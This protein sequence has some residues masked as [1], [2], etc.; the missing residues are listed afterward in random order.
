MIGQ[1][2]IINTAS[3]ML[4]TFLPAISRGSGMSVEALGRVIFARDMTGLLGPAVGGVVRRAGAWRTMVWAGVLGAVGMLLVPF[5]VVGIVIGLV[6]WGLCRTSFIIALNSW[7]GDAVAYERRAR[8]TGLVEL[9]W[10]AAALIGLPLM[11]VLIDAVGWWMAPTILGLLG[12]PFAALMARIES[13]AKVAATTTQ[14]RSIVMSRNTIFALVAVAL[15]TGAAQFLLFTHGL[16]LES[17][18][19]FDPAQVGFAIVAVGAAEAVASYGTSLITDRLGKR[20]GVIAGTVVLAAALA[21]FSA[22]PAPALFIGLGLLVIAFLGFEFAIVSSIAMV[23][24]LEPE[25]RSAAIGRS[26]GLSTVARAGVSLL[27]GWLYDVVSFRTIMLLATATA[28]AAIILL[29]G[30]VVEPA[31]TENASDPA[32]A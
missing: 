27:C 3:R 23:S 2:L 20:N 28:V 22:L 16:W 1:R 5:G 7:L 25:G 6:L 31:G 13:Q 21:G 32:A 14:H 8:A 9:T 11:G 18:Y 4:F 10:A 17:T 29:L 24:E 12:L 30:F 26:V 15:M 19:D